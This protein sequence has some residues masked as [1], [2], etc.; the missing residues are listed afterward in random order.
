MRSMKI[1]ICG[2]VLTILGFAAFCTAETVYDNE[3]VVKNLK[4]FVDGKEFVVKGMA[5]NPAPLGILDM[6]NEYDGTGYCSAKKTVFGEYKSACFG[7]DYFD[8]VTA[9]ANR[10][11][12]GPLGS[13]GKPEPFWQKVWER[14]LKIMQK[15]GVNTI[16]IYNMN[17]L[18]KTF[19]EM[20]PNEYKVTDKNMAAIHSTFFD[21]C[22]KYGFKVMAPIVTDQSFITNTAE[23]LVK[24]HIEAEITELGN[25]P[26]L[27]MWIVGN[28]LP[29]YTDKNLLALVNKYM[30]VVRTRQQAL[31][32]RRIPVSHAVMDLPVQ[33]SYMMQNLDVDIFVTNAGYRD[34]YMEPL[35]DGEGEFPGFTALSKQYNKAL[36]IGEMGMH[37]N[38]DEI[39]QA[40][41]DWFNQQWKIVVNRTQDGCVGAVF[42]EYSD[43]SQ[44]GS[45]E[46]TMDAHMGAL[47]PKAATQNGKTSTD[48]DAFIPDTM[49]EKEYV[50]DSIVSGLPDSDFKDYNMNADVFQLLG[51]AAETIDVVPAA[52][53]SNSP[54]K[55]SSGEEEEPRES[56]G[57]SS[58]FIKSMFLV[59][60]L[61][62]ILS[63]L[64]TKN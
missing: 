46:N 14:D 13:N 1:W 10:V 37:Q 12:A 25:H 24:K 6:K 30:G 4:L 60:L 18:T 32:N 48:A 62:I 21:M 36:L 57:S 20:Y 39:T 8:G 9:E 19:F 53:G 64:V 38:G 58:V 7:S 15:M 42:F 5:Y 31:W 34:V 33:Y 54:V 11:P 23:D 40:R 55:A 61:V 35:W 51:R 28:E 52:T 56:S 59:T 29:L 63:V 17:L 26:A 50:Y 22:H 43:E 45:T 16:R 44:K 49:T 2:I 27:L 47:V 3:V 41:P